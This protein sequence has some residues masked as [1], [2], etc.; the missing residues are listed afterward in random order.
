MRRTRIKFCGIRRPEDAD[1]AVALGV[2]AIG[3]VLVPGAARAVDLTPAAA[4]RRRLPA[5]VACVALLRDPQPDWIQQVIEQ[6]SPD[7]LQFHGSEPAALCSGFGLRWLKALPMGEEPRCATTARGGPERPARDEP[8]QGQA[9]DSGQGMADTQ[10]YAGTNDLERQLA[11]YRNAAGVVLDG[12]VPGQPGGQGRS[13]D[14]RRVRDWHGPPLILAG[15]LSAD[16]VSRAI[17]Q[18]TPFAVD[19]SSGIETDA[20]LRPGIKDFGRMAEFVAAVRQA[21]AATARPMD[22]HN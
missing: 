22:S 8:G 5:F 2:D 7:L 6:I 20:R 21:D 1:A 4:I 14:W 10:T 16:N 11:E 19:V 3:L 9:A 15:G 17:A 12:H 18:A 13:F